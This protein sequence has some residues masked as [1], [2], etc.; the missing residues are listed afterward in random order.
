MDFNFDDVKTRIIDE[1]AK[2]KEAALAEKRGLI[3]GLGLG[4]AV[5]GPLSGGVISA[6]CGIGIVCAAKFVK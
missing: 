6:L 4:V 3:I 2:I 5:A 1:V